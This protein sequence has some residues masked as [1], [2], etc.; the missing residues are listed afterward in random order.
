MQ[1][2]PKSVATKKDYENLL[3]MPEF[4]R[5]AKEDLAMLAT[6]NKLKVTRAIRPVDPNKPDGEWVMEEIDTPHPTWQRRGFETLKEVSD[7][8][9]ISLPAGV[10]IVAPV[11]LPAVDKP[12]DTEV[13][14]NIDVPSLGSRIAKG[15]SGMA[16]KFWPKR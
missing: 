7:M 15:I 13:I 5:Q 16:K 1:G 11:A 12:A 8:A 14:E 4:A 10:K 3:K 2:Y 6:A 9:S